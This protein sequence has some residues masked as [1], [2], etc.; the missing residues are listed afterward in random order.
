MA[1]GSIM[2][3]MEVAEFFDPTV[4]SVPWLFAHAF[5]TLDGDTTIV[6]EIAAEKI[7]GVAFNRHTGSMDL[8]DGAYVKLFLIFAGQDRPLQSFHAPSHVPSPGIEGA[9]MAIL[10]IEDPG[11]RIDSPGTIAVGRLIG[12]HTYIDEVE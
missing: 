6:R 10:E 12:A 11:Y 9:G 5:D 8:T 1:K 4:T 2:I 3:Q 7:G